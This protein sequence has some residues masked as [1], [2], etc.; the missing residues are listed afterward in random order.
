MH[1]GRLAEKLIAPRSHKNDLESHFTA[2]REEI[3]LFKKF[4]FQVGPREE[5]LVSFYLACARMCPNSRRQNS[6]G[7]EG[8][9][10]KFGKLTDPATLGGSG[11]GGST[12]A[13]PLT[14]WGIVRPG[15]TAPGAPTLWAS[16][17]C[18]RQLGWP[19]IPGKSSAADDLYFV[20]NQTD[21]DT[22][23]P[24][25]SGRPARVGQGAA[26]ER[27]SS[28][29]TLSLHDNLRGGSGFFCFGIRPGGSVLGWVDVGNHPPW[30]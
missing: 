30:V 15:I 4:L 17:E 20:M 3:S 10:G 25:L 19:A 6:F 21:L 5:A 2:S 9:G 28:S 1:A 27:R 16:L 7:A 26:G 8:T 23:A 18:L 12:P 24:L 29:W 22:V 14:Y 13:D 11:G